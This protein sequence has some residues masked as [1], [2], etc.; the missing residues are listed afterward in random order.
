MCYVCYR[1]IQTYSKT[2]LREEKKFNYVSQQV[3]AMIRIFDLH[4]PKKDFVSTDQV[5]NG[6]FENN[7]V[8]AKGDIEL[9]LDCFVSTIVC[10]ICMKLTTN[11]TDYVLRLFDRKRV[12][13]DRNHVGTSFPNK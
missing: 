6:N 5:D 3:A 1:V 11:S 7:E 9:L 4:N 13:N 8:L 10:D 2:L 12:A